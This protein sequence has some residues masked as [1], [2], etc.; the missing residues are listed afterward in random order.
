MCLYYVRSYTKMTDPKEGNSGGFKGLYIFWTLQKN[1]C[2]S[3]WF[4]CVTI[5]MLSLLFCFWAR[6][7][8]QRNWLPVFACILRKFLLPLK[9]GSDISSI[10]I[11][12]CAL[13]FCSESLLTI[14]YWL[15]LL[16]ET[17]PAFVGFRPAA[18]AVHFMKRK[19]LL[20][21]VNFFDHVRGRCFLRFLT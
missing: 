2:K 8:L 21:K 12:F 6:W 10:N 20:S 11:Y 19:C 4:I 14:D 9:I 7:K 1:I 16:S 15:F 3:M 17:S 18:H 13:Y 5:F